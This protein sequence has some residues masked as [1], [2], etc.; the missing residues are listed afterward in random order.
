MD[1]QQDQ[2]EQQEQPKEGGYLENL[3]TEVGAYYD[4]M[5]VIPET[6]DDARM[7]DVELLLQRAEW[8]MVVIARTGEIMGEAKYMVTMRTAEKLRLYR[9]YTA[10]E[11]K[12]LVA[13]DVAD[14]Q[15]VYDRAE[16]LNR[17]ATHS[18]EMVRSVVSLRKTEMTMQY[19]TSSHIA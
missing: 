1:E 6:L 17:A 11:Q 9:G 16:R 19:Q 3:D 7:Q 13:G 2:Q 14:E 12:M 4:Q 8:L 5:T 18:L 15:R 10:T